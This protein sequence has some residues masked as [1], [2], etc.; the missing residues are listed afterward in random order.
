M[1]EQL[2]NACLDR[3]SEYKFK[4]PASKL[5][6][7]NHDLIDEGRDSSAEVHRTI[8]Y[9]EETT[10]AQPHAPSVSEQNMTPQ[11]DMVPVSSDRLTGRVHVEPGTPGSTTAAHKAKSIGWTLKPDV[12]EAKDFDLDTLS[13]DPSATL[14]SM[15][16]EAIRQYKDIVDLNP[17]DFRLLNWH[18]ANLEYSNATNYNK[19]SLQGWDIDAGNEW[20]GK[21][22]M[23]VGGYQSVARGLLMCPTPLNVRHKAAVKR[24]M[25]HTEGTTGPARIECE[26]GTVV[27]ADFIVNTIPL[28]VLKHGNVEFQPPLPSWKS[29][30]IRRLG[31]GVLNKVILVYKEPFWDQDRDIFGILSDPPHRLSLDQKDYTS[32]RGRFFQWFNATNT[33]GLPCLLALMAGDAGFDTEQ[34]PNDDLIAEATNV[35]RSRFGDKV[36]PPIEAVVTRWASDK[37]ARGSYSSAGVNMRAEDY[38]IMARPI[39]NLFFAGEHTIVTHPATVHGAYLSGLRAASE[40]LE[41]LIGPI[42]VPNPLIIPKETSSSLKRK[43]LEGNKDPAQARLEAY[44]LDVW[45]HIYS[46]LGYRPL[47]P[48]KVA[49]NAYLLYNK[50]NYDVARKKCEEGRRAGKGKPSPN[51]V[52]VM[53]SKMWKEATNEERKPYD[54]QADEQKRAHAQAVKDWTAAAAKWDQDALEVRAAY[55]KEHPSVPTAE[56]QTVAAAGPD[57]GRRIKIES[58]AGNADRDIDMAA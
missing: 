52:R 23:V 45:Q 37:F 53:T 5:I 4:L 47:K 41:A 33:T 29:D 27:D 9:V 20:E 16:D 35:L 42:E 21:H 7:G 24:I 18:I 28:G 30:A 12:T 10:A 13:K 38:D 44:E 31:Y 6:E 48:S 36:P 14:G 56:E 49:G 32:R 34:T 3:V 46:K 17:Q 11:V 8:A 25:Y 57:S 1:V 39:G 19:L 43:A 54:E 40:V 50:A 26:D 15:M 55:E 58:S 22:T 51:E 2:Y